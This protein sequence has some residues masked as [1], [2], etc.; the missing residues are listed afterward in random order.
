MPG[1]ATPCAHATRAG[2]RN[3]PRLRAGGSERSAIRKSSG[4]QNF[5]SQVSV[6]GHHQMLTALLVKGSVGVSPTLIIIQCGHP[7]LQRPTIAVH[8]SVRLPAG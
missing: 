6:L 4:F 2:G 8:S 1:N 3:P 7:P 5:G